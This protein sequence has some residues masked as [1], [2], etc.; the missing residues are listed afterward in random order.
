MFAG[1]NMMVEEM[2]IRRRFKRR[3]KFRAPAYAAL[4]LAALA[5]SSQDG[6][7][8]QSSDGQA[9]LQRNCGKCHGVAPGDSSPLTKAPNLSIVLGSYPGER[10][11]V[12]LSEGIGSRHPDMPQIQFSD[13]DITSIYYYLHGNEP[14]GKERAP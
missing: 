4:V 8:A 2:K 3:P 7:A 10:L 14:D 5:C 6:V 9:L 12:E 11:E 13:E 1:V